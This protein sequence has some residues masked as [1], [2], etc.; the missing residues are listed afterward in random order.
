LVKVKHLAA[1][2]TIWLIGRDD[3]W[4]SPLEIIAEL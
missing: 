4:L 3:V 2:S 1:A